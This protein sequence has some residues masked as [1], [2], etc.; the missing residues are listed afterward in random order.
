MSRATVVFVDESG[1]SQLP[2]VRRTWALKGETPML[3]HNFNR[4][5]VSMISGITPTGRLYF[6]IFSVTIKK[7]Q[8]LLFLEDLRRTIRRPIFVLWDGSPTHRA[9]AVKAYLKNR[10]SRFK[11]YPLPPY[12]PDLNPDEKVWNQLKYHELANYAPRTVKELRR[13]V[14][15]ALSKIGRRPKLVRSFVKIQLLR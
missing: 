1:A 14:R 9:G 15:I 2:V 4:G 13:R 3:V 10:R 12:A 8:V 7:E 11:A 6:R 5:G